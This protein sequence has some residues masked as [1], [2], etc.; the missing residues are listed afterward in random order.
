MVNPAPSEV[1]PKPGLPVSAWEKEILSLIIIDLGEPERYFKNHSLFTGI[2]LLK[3][4]W[5][6]VGSKETIQKQMIKLLVAG[7]FIGVLFTLISI[8]LYHAAGK[9]V[10]CASCHSMKEVGALWQQSRHK[11]FACIEC[12]LPDSNIAAQVAYK[13][14]AG[15][16][17][18]YHETLRSYPASI[19]ISPEA[20]DIAE[21]NCLRCHFS[22]VENT[23]MAGQG[24]DCLKCHRGLVH[25]KGMETG[26]IKVE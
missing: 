8:G 23:F 21:G 26:G 14:K 18:L 6:E 25:G 12:H 17:D 10:F 15:L 4:G 24:G 19:K 7:A 22:T 3:G 9:P 13:T 1:M 2:Y 16:N 5:F 20:K 11:Q